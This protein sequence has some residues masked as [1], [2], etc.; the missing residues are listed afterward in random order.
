[1]DFKLPWT[2]EL[3][4]SLKVGDYVYCYVT[5]AFLRV[6]CKT[7]AG[8][9]TV[10]CI[11]CGDYSF[12]PCYG[13]LGSIAPVDYPYYARML[14]EVRKLLEGDRDFIARTGYEH[15]RGIC[16]HMTAWKRDVA[17]GDPSP[18]GRY[19]RFNPVNG[20]LEVRDGLEIAEQWRK[21]NEKGN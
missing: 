15:R 13:G 1:M 8:P 4:D 11:D 16:Q 9:D 7:P 19:R 20:E 18:D 10:E 12:Y 2:K 17:E 6:D 5:Q 21:A 14:D 3:W